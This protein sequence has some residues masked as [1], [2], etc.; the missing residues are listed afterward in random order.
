MNAPTEIP[1][2]TIDG[3]F[4]DTHKR[5]SLFAAQSDELRKIN[6]L[7]ASDG[8]QH[9][10]DP[11]LAKQADAAMETLCDPAHALDAPAL[12]IARMRYIAVRD[13]SRYLSDKKT[14]L[15]RSIERQ[16]E[17]QKQSKLEK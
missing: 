10:L 12:H 1:I 15:I 13:I 14:A 4:A 3:T 7:L 2:E 5:H 8:W 9:V 11:Y 6:D 16:N 17:Q